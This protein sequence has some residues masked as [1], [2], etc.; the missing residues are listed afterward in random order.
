MVTTLEW[1]LIGV[2][3]TGWLT[4]WVMMEVARDRSPRHPYADALLQ[5]VSSGHRGS[6]V[7]PMMDRIA[8]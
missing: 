2:I 5:R 1:I 3:V 6:V 4:H 8:S 7:A